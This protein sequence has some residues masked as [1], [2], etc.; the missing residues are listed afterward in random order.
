MEVH[1]LYALLWNVAKREELNDPK[2]M[3]TWHRDYNTSY[4]EEIEKW[5]SLKM[6]LIEKGYE[7]TKIDKDNVISVF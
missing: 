7:I 3:C 6:Y 4:K 5:I 2:K 1:S